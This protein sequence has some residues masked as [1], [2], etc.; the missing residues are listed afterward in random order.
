[1]SNEKIMIS[2]CETYHNKGGVPLYPQRYV[3]VLS[4]HN[5]ACGELA[6][7]YDSINAFFINT[8]G[9]KYLAGHF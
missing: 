8:Q 5:T 2:F 6:P 9:Q 7:V 1:M 3:K 4:F